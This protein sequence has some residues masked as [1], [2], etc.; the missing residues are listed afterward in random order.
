MQC[1]EAASVGTRNR[2]L[3]EHSCSQRLEPPANPGRFSAL[4]TCCPRGEPAARR[5]APRRFQSVV[6][7]R[8]AVD[9][10]YGRS[11]RTA[12][13]WPESKSGPLKE[14]ADRLCAVSGTDQPVTTARLRGGVL[15]D[16][17]W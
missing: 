6:G 2:W 12:E 16:D 7:R 3:A 5:N 11:R 15:S 8:I 14:V 4:C 9:E 13:Q 10:A 1:Y 17:G